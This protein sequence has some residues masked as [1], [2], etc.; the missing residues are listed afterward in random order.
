MSEYRCG[1][2]VHESVDLSVNIDS[3]SLGLDF[4]ILTI[5]EST[6]QPMLQNE[7][8]RPFMYEEKTR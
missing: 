7:L 5:T 1:K 6:V 3:I 2:L 4:N 8:E